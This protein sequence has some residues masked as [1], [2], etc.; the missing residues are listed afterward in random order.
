V[1]QYFIVE[2]SAEV[3]SLEYIY[4]IQN[5]TIQCYK[6]S[7]QQSYEELEEL[8]KEQDSLVNNLCEQSQSLAN[9]VHIFESKLEEQFKKTKYFKKQLWALEK[10][11]YDLQAKNQVSI[12]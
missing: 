3:S 7:L 4:H 10:E 6:G 8:L 12:Q 5:A 2:S 9:E 11:N 1:L